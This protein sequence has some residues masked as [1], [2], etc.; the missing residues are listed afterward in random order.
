MMRLPR[1]E[2]VAPESL[3][4]AL[5]VL[6]SA[7]VGGAMVVAGGTDLIPNMKRRQQTPGT[8]VGLRRIPELQRMANGDGLAIGAGVTLTRVIH[9]LR[10]AHTPALEGLRQAAAQ[11]A[12]PH[13]RNMGTIGGNL[14]LDTRCNYYDQN[15]EWR[16]AIDFCMKKDGEI[17]WVAPSSPR[18]LAVSSTDTAP[19]L[20]SLGASV[21]LASTAGERTIPLDE[22]YQ[23]DGIQYL[24]RRPDEILT[25]IRIPR[26]DGW[27][28][29]YWKLRRRGSFDFPVLSVAAAAKIQTDGTVEAA[30]IVIGSVASRAIDAVDA[31]RLLAGQ[32]LT[33]GQ[34]AAAAERAWVP[35]R[36]VDNTDFTL[37]WR[38]RMSRAFVSYA[39]RELRGDDVRED[40]RRVARQLL[41]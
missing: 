36:P 40:R 26:L 31:G 4:E 37:H 8:L 33:D 3:A 27:R 28:S 21:T 24:T 30:R 41:T 12:T 39:L 9:E 13:L 25:S 29:T 6:A 20:L 1:F 2:F 15:Y 17:C 35:A 16:K 5:D 18:C 14:C 11:V 23:N 34:I 38:K 19:A 22:L 7:T 32:P 10:R